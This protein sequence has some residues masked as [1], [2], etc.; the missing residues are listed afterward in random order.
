MEYELVAGTQLQ[1]WNPLS[2]GAAQDMGA[3]EKGKIFID[4]LLCWN[5]YCLPENP[6][7]LLKPL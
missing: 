4:R 3:L 7:V 1:A 5:S 6:A 2:T